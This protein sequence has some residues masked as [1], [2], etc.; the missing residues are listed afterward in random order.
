M[1]I[2]SYNLVSDVSCWLA[3]IEVAAVSGRLVDE[4]DIIIGCGGFKTDD[5]QYAPI[6][7]GFPKYYQSY[8]GNAEWVDRTLAGL[9]EETR[10]ILAKI[11]RAMRTSPPASLGVPFENE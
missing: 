3:I 8:I 5:N 6:F 10:R 9:P 1:V 2:N 4:K 11:L 7:L